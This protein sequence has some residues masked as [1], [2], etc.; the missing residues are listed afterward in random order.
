LRQF[1]QSAVIEDADIPPG[2]QRVRTPFG[3]RLVPVRE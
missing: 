1:E 3:D 2:M